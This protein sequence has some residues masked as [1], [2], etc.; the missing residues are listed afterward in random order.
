MLA[1]LVTASPA[2]PILAKQT[3]TAYEGKEQIIEAG[4][5][6]RVTKDGVDFWTSGT[7]TKRS[8]V[9]GRL[10]DRRGTG[11][12]HGDAVGSKRIAQIVKEAGGD[13]VII[14]GQRQDQN[15][16]IFTGNMAV[17]AK[18]QFTEMVVLKY[19]D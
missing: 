15:G 16:Y 2:S 13:A 19:L 11:A 6:T 4:G 10:M 14:A 9:I 8:K 5:G 3:F 17:A 1:I 7:P 12:F 18:K